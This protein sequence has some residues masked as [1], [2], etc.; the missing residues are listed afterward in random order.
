[1][2]EH[3]LE[4]P[5]VRPFHL[6]LGISVIIAA[7]LLSVV[8][9]PWIVIVPTAGAALLWMLFRYPTSAMGLFLAWMPF[10]FLAVMSG[11]FFGVPMIEVVSKTKQPLLLLLI[12][13]L[14]QRNGLRFAMPDLFLLGLFIIA[15]IHKIFGGEFAAFQDDF[16]FLLPYFAGRVTVL[17]A[18][19]EQLWTR[20]AVWIVALLSALGM[21]EL[22]VFGE[23]PRT[24]LYLALGNA[25]SVE[26]GGLTASFH[27]TGYGGLREASTMIGPPEFGALCMIVLIIWWVYRENRI[28][29]GIVAVGLVCALTRSAWVGTAFA[30]LVLAVAMREGKRLT[31]Y[32]VL[33]LAIFAAAIPILSLT[34]YLYFTKTGQDTSTEWREETILTGIQ[35]IAEHPLGTGV[36]SIGGRAIVGNKNAL[37]LETSYLSFGGEYGIA[38]LGCFL[39]FLLSAFRIV[40]HER[41]SLG[42]AASGIM[43][44]VSVM[45]I[46]FILHTDFRLNC[47]IWFPIGLAVRSAV[48]GPKAALPELTALPGGST[49]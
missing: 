48:R 16:A 15:S 19:R 20:C 25:I 3:S 27:G 32:A 28:A 10:E 18:T 38:A 42:F 17:T 44:A 35:Y 45:M 1:M 39:G 8:L 36:G 46:V 41:S 30:F 47:W 26:E 33:S 43:I 6:G 37:V 13:I 23:G 21:L 9:R 7:V 29:G 22:F 4:N 49:V 2:N 14:W 24:L 34:D 40:W 12:L 5:F 31:L 11:R